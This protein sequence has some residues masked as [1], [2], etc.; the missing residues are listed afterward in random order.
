MSFIVPA[1]SVLELLFL[2]QKVTEEPIK[3]NGYARKNNSI[4]LLFNGMNERVCS[5]K[6]ILSATFIKKWMGM[7]RKKLYPNSF[8]PI[9]RVCSGKN[10]WFGHYVHFSLFYGR[11]NIKTGY[12]ASLR[13]WL[14]LEIDKCE[15]RIHIEGKDIFIVIYP[16]VETAQLIEDCFIC[17]PTL[18][19]IAVFQSTI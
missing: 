13:R 16:Y 5:G 4:G 10:T 17:L 6:E 12:Y 3:V 2:I 11:T 7:L 18:Q 15:F 8:L 14:R 19:I 9:E 1:I